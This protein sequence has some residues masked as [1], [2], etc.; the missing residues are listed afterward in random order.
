LIISVRQTE[1]FEGSS[2][3]GCEAKTYYQLHS[4]LFFNM[5]TNQSG[6]RRRKQATEKA[7]T[8]KKKVPKPTN[9]PSPADG[10]NEKDSDPTLASVFF[11]HPL[12]R[13]GRFILIPYLLF[14]ALNCVALQHPEWV[15]LATF[16]ILKLRPSLSPFDERQVLIV[17]ASVADNRLVASKLSDILKLEVAHETFDS[18]H[19]YCRDGSTSWYQLM[20]FLPYAASSHD[21]KTNVNA[22]LVGRR[23]VEAFQELCIQRSSPLVSQVLDP[24]K[25]AASTECSS[26]EV[27]S[28]C[29]S[30]ECF[31]TLQNMWDCA[32]DDRHQSAI[33]DPERFC[34]PAFRRVLHQT[35]H[36]L[37]TIQ[38][39]NQTYCAS[40]KME[41]SFQK[42]VSGFFPHRDWDSIDSCLEMITWYTLD[43]ESTMLRSR[44]AGVV[45]DMFPLESTSPCEVAALAEFTDPANALYAPHVD[46]LTTLCHS[47]ADVA[48]DNKATSKHIFVPKASKKSQANSLTWED[49]ALE[50][51]EESK[52]PNKKETHLMELLK[53]LAK[54]LGYGQGAEDESSE[55]I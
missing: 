44:Q 16:G 42:I 9:E 10:A 8:N 24:R 46:R 19:N 49:L 47:S 29:W 45:H 3:T 37:S 43:F 18:L 23:K 28:S 36:P 13:V 34:K 31:Y 30:K 39:L 17:G 7:K 55:F 1:G 11:G 21:K 40:D 52:K 27:W 51:H 25:Y 4:F 54:D 32:N 38:Q 20:R 33:A 12:I 15:G 35:R 53:N 6:L 41:H 50:L 48:A 5:T 14:N 26:R 2:Y 22:T